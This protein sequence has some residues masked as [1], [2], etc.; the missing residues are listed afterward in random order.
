MNLLQPIVIIGAARSGTT[1]L[2]KALSEHPDVAYIEEPNV[3][4]RYNNAKLRSDYFPPHLATGNV[5]SYI[6]QKFYEYVEKAGKSRLLEKTPSNALRLAFVRRILP[7][8]KIIHVVRDGREV[9]V[10]AARKWTSEIDRNRDLP[11]EDLPFRNLRKQVKKFTQIPIHDY[12]YY[13]GD[14]SSS[15]L[16]K[17][18]LQ[19]RKVWGPRFPGI[20]DLVKVHTVLEVCAL[21]W[22]ACIEVVEREKPEIKDED[23]LEIRYEE[24]C[25]SPR[26]HIKEILSFANLTEPSNLQDIVSVVRPLSSSSWEE[27]VSLEEKHNVI[28]LIGATLHHLGYK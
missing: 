22:K 6:N 1:V 2:A 26:E 14:I 21:Q 20:Y 19:G 27:G 28:R 8:S 7:N 13:I 23:F 9:A 15:V 17:M 4:W 11:G 16:F 3:I 10:S 24:F 5:V 12:P 18:G 25:E